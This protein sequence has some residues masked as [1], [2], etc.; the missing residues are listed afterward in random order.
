MIM[1]SFLKNNKEKIILILIILLGAFFRS[2]N[3]N[4][5]QGAHLHP[6]E[7]AIIMFTT[8]L[9]FPK[10]FDEFLSPQ[11]PLNPHFFAYG[12]FP[13]YLL[14]ITGLAAGNFNPSFTVYDNLN[15]VGRFM[16]GVFDIATIIVIFFLG[17]KLFG[18]KTGLLASFF[19]TISV[20][21]I[22][23]SH[24]YA[25]DIPLTFF[26]LLTLYQLIRFY[27]KPS[28]KNSIL[29]GVFFGVSLATKISAL[30]LLSA[31]T[32]AIT[33]DFLLLVI[34]QPH[35]PHVWLP[36]LPRFLKRLI[37]D[38]IVILVSTVVIFVILQPY[39]IIDFNTFLQQNMEQSQMTRDAFTFP[40]TLQYV[41][42]IPYFYELKNVFLWGQGPVLASLS[43]IG[44]LYFTYFGLIKKDK[45]QKWA[46]ETIL[47]VFFWIY[48]F[49]VGKFAVGWMRYMLPLYPLLCLFGA[50][51]A[52][53]FLKLLKR[54]LGYWYLLVI[55]VFIGSIL[56]WPLSFMHIYT[57]PNTRVL[58][59]EW[60]Y[61]NIPADKN[62]AREHW[63]DGLPFGGNIVYKDFELPIYGM[64]DPL[65]KSQIYQ[66]IQKTDYI[67]IASNRL[68]VPLQ[69][70]SKNCQ[71]WNLPKERCSHNANRYYQRLFNQKLGFKK[72]AEFENPPTL[73][74]LNISINDQ[75][76]DESF[77]VYDHPKVMIFK[78]TN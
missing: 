66:T 37:I 31:I 43:F 44:A 53:K 3:L 38:G 56:Y 55:L 9:Q 73:P 68:Y 52:Y 7:R 1:K 65:T 62:I 48:F 8:P 34:K 46:Q 71:K 23:A 40:Y 15:L 12:N 28:L 67:I 5:D 26:I 39:A 29:V 16:S 25:V 59:S 64:E 36:H 13:L 74:F 78:K 61:K 17:K 2:Y 14:K 72:V 30:P 22:Q 32:A 50:L 27:E 47:A 77:T 69:K 49:V 4:W 18:K 57:K 51:F 21:P 11:S 58:A 76:A 42:K 41:G 54:K 45:K 75:A 10:N 19:Y 20:F 70:I 33:I 24:F 6:D 60:I 35:K 63:D